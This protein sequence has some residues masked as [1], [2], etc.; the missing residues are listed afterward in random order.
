M[1]QVN[2]PVSPEKELH[3]GRLLGEVTRQL[4]DG[5][6]FGKI[7]D[8]LF[9]T[10]N[11]II[12]YDRIGIALVEGEG[13]SRQITAKWLKTKL[14]KVHLGGGY[15]ALL[16]G[17]SLEKILVSGQPRILNDLFE[18]AQDHPKSPSTQLML[19]EGIRSSLT[20][21]LKADGKTMGLVF[22]SCTRPNA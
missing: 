2:N 6:D 19:M 17:S 12:P 15:S 8:F 16:K 10:L 3:L 20:C 1:P 21:P 9:E 22:F 5:H 14:P 7:F 18:Y 4:S 11:L 13:D